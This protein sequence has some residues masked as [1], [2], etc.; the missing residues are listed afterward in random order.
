MAFQ[1][2]EQ[3]INATRTMTDTEAEEYFQRVQT[4]QTQ[5]S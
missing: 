2:T 4:A 5:Q 1:A 3:L